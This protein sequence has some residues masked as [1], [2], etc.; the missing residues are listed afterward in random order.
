MI[1]KRFISMLVLLAAVIMCARA[2][3][4][5]G[6]YTATA[7]ETLGSITVSSDATLIIND[8]VTV[9]VNGGI[10]VTSGTLTIVGHGTLV[11]N[12][13]NG[14]NGAYD[15]GNG[16]TGGT[17]ISGNI[18]VKGATVNATGGAGGKGGASC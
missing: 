11:V 3:W 12:G 7:T 5:G 4:T 15:G 18:I 6:T 2:N 1:K 13:K 9:T 16:D 14:N 10:K 8:G 17:A